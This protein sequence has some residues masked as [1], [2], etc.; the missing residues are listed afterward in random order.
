MFQNERVDERLFLLWGMTC[1]VGL[2]I[3]ITY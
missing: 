3:F 1:P 2:D